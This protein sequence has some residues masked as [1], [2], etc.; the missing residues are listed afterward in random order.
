MTP[1]SC[2]RNVV[3]TLEANG[4]FVCSVTGSAS[5]SARTAT[6]GP[7]RPP[8]RMRDDAVARDAGLDLEAELAQVVGDERGRLLLAVRQL[9]ILVKLVAN[10]GQGRRELRGVL[11]DARQRILRSHGHGQDAQGERHQLETGQRGLRGAIVV[12]CQAPV[13]GLSKSRGAGGLRATRFLLGPQ[14]DHR[15]DA[16]RAPARDVARGQQ[17]RR[18]TATGTTASISGSAA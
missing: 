12:R 2:P 1:T 8:L 7:G 14:R 17:S 9:R 5:M 3:R 16:N 6:T 4:R 13:E 11:I 10:L 18:A 15:I